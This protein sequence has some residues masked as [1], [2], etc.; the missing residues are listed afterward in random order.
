MRP[1]FGVVLATF[2]AAPAAAAPWSGD[3]YKTGRAGHAGYVFL[4]VAPTRPAIFGLTI[5]VKLHCTSP[6]NRQDPNGNGPIREQDVI[7]IHGDGSFAFRTDYD[8]DLHEQQKWHTVVSARFSPDGKTVSG[9]ARWYGR[10][11]SGRRC[12]TPRRHFSAPVVRHENPHPAPA[13]SP[14]YPLGD[15]RG[16]FE[17][18]QAITFTIAAGPSGS[19][20]SL[21]RDLHFLT[22]WSCDGSPHT[23][24]W[25]VQGPLRI[26]DDGSVNF[27]DDSGNQV[28]ATAYDDG[29]IDGFASSQPPEISRGDGSNRTCNVGDTQFAARRSRGGFRAEKPNR[30]PI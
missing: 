12:D 29:T 11:N 6:G 13:T 30:L 10:S 24:P 14:A 15:Y 26:T 5:V 17:T 8:P 21:I 1:A 20:Y 2:A 23:T 3:V 7:R 16:K 9:T 4:R 25:P 27:A 22:E 28:E 19:D 18:G